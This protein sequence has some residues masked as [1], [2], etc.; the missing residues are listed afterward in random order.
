MKKIILLLIVV[1]FISTAC[2][3]DSSSPIKTKEL[4]PAKI[5]NKWTYLVTTGGISV[6][7]VNEIVSDELVNDIKWYN[8]AL[9]SQIVMQ[10]RNAND[11]MHVLYSDSNSVNRKDVLFYKYPVTELTE[12]DADGNYVKIVSLDKKVTVPAGT[13]SCYY[14]NVVYAADSSK[15]EEYYAPGVGVVK[16]VEYKDS[17]GFRKPITTTELES[18]NLK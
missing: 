14:Y 9:N 4:F 16:L 6:N 1:L 11:G 17:L 5:G 7:K 2:S 10:L 3:D 15:Y 13:F 12:Y 8:L 18:Y